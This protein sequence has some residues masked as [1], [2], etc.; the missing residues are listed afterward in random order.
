MFKGYEHHKVKDSMLIDG[1]L[2]H[3]T[4]PGGYPLYYILHSDRL[5]EVLCVD[6]A[7]D[8]YPNMQDYE[9]LYRDVNW[10]NQN[11]WCE[12]GHKIESAYGEA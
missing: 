3:C 12:H 2:P 9:E 8:Y 11:F 1:K 5:V 4:I 7:N 10:E 6:C